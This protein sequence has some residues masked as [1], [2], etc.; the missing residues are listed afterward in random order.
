M[1]VFWEHPTGRKPRGRPKTHWRD[2]ISYL[3]WENLGFLL[4]ELEDV[5]R[6]NDVWSTLLSLLR[7]QSRPRKAVDM[8]G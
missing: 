1:E 2:Y 5:T 6:A 3:D 8:N 7:V 4:E